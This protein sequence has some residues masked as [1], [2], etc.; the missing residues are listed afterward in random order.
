MC[1]GSI[2]VTT[3]WWF[4]TFFIFASI[5]NNHQMWLI[6]FR[7]VQTTNQIRIRGKKRKL[8]SV[9]LQTRRR[10]CLLGF[11][12]H[13]A[14]DVHTKMT[15]PPKQVWFGIWC[16]RVTIPP[17]HD[18]IWLYNVQKYTGQTIKR[19]Q[20][21]LKDESQTSRGDCHFLFALLCLVNFST[22]QPDQPADFKVPGDISSFV[23]DTYDIWSGD[24]RIIFHL[25]CDISVIS[26]VFCQRFLLMHYSL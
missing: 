8:S 19:W 18:Y 15:L 4:G 2:S 13:T 17:K 6:F 1:V 7:G 22:H 11:A 24:S 25:P 21:G 3:G 10:S 16:S 14:H 5:G 12:V 26:G 20:S 9:S 23:E